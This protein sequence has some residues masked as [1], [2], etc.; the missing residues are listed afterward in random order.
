M[1]SNSQ[2]IDR[3][4]HYFEITLG[5]LCQKFTFFVQIKPIWQLFQSPAYYD[6]TDISR[7][8]ICERAKS[9]IFCKIISKQCSLWLKF[10]LLDITKNLNIYHPF[11]ARIF[12]TILAVLY[13]SFS[14]GPNVGLIR[15][16][17][18]FGHFCLL[19]FKFSA[20]LV[21]TRVLLEGG[22][23]SRIHGN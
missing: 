19:F 5:N 9:Q 7:Y 12:K 20:G 13:Y 23:Y 22:S 3:R 6:M 4:L 16:W 11:D 21:K 14:E 1:I 17:S 15:I 2:H 18:K 10:W 8:G